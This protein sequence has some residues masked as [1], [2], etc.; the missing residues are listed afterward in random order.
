VIV[1]ALSLSAVVVA[2]LLWWAMADVFASDHLARLNYRGRPL[3]V[4]AGLVI[5]LTVVAVTGVSHLLAAAG[6]LDDELDSLDRMAF[7]ALGFGLLGL[8]DDL[9]G[10]A[11]RRGFRGHIAAMFSGQL[12]TGMVKLG[13]GVVVAMTVVDGSALEVVRQGLIVAAAANLGNLFDRAPGR[14]V[15][16]SVLGLAIVAV[17]GVAATAVVGPAVAVAAAL[18]L[19][20][21]DLRERCM[22][23]DTG[24]NV[25]GAAI[26]LGLVAALGADGQW[27]ALGVLVALNLL[28]EVVSFSRVIDRVAPLRWV[29][30]W[31]SQRA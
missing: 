2:S 20:V 16:V 11:H 6:A 12:T 26:G 21:P 22:L 14:V 19:A 30:R 9:L 10:D 13:G 29:D 17:C 18:A 5:V 8:V 7:L 25:L 1:V 4:G 28:S 3:P 15:K 31:G 24:S 23:G 27:V